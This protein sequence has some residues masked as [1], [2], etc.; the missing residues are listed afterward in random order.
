MNEQTK[1]TVKG[2]SD[3]INARMRVR[4]LARTAGLNTADQ[5]RIALATSSLAQTLRMGEKFRGE[6]TIQ[7][8]SNDDKGSGVRIVCTLFSPTEYESTLKALKDTKWMLMVD[9]LNVQTLPSSNLEVTAI[10]WAA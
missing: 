1:I 5:A 2:H 10:K 4:R 7:S 9:E 8:M 6:I 3:I